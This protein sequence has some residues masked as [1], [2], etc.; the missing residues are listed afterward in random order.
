MALFFDSE[1]FDSRLASAGLRRADAAAALGLTEAEIAELW[2]DQRELGA[3]D[4]R[5]LAALLGVTREEVAKRAGVSTP[6]PRDAEPGVDARLSRIEG[7]LAEIKS[8]LI[9]LR[10]RR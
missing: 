3:R 9:E 2:K 8:I 6:V 10:S 4:V 5:L 7:D 1:W